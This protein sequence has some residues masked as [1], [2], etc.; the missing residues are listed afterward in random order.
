MA[1]E[2]EATGRIA[3]LGDA[4]SH[5]LPVP[6]GEKES[7]PAVPAFASKANVLCGQD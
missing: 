5:G 2:T 7:P 6:A 1:E 4:E 3:V